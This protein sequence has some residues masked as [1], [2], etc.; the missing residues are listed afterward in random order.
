VKITSSLFLAAQGK[1]ACGRQDGSIIIISAT[2]AAITQFLT[3]DNTN[4]A[5]KSASHD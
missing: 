1:I 4:P 2:K 5:G 3:K